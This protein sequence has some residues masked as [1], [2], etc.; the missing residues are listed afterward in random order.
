MGGDES[1]GEG[2]SGGGVAKGAG[3]RQ[4]VTGVA[5]GGVDAW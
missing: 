2:V 5:A 3:P 1:R 4:T